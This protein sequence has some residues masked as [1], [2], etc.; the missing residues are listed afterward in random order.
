MTTGSVIRTN[1]GSL[2]AQN[3]LNRIY[4]QITKT[5]E[6][7]STGYKVNS[8]SDDAA[9]YA[10]GNRMLSQIM[11]TDVAVD[12]MGDGISLIATTD[13]GLTEI[14]NILQRIRE[15]TVGVQNGSNSQKDKEAVSYEIAALKEE[16]N[17]VSDTL[18]F[19]GVKVFQGTTVKI[20]SG[21]NDGDMIPV[22]VPKFSTQTLGIADFSV[23]GPTMTMAVATAAD[24]QKAFGATTGVTTN[25]VTASA[26]DLAGR[27][28][29]ATASV[30]FDTPPVALVDTNTNTWF[31]RVTITAAD[32][33][34]A[35][36]LK[37][38]G[39]NVEATVPKEF[40][41]SLDPK[42]AVVTGTNAAFTVDTLNLNL[43]RINLP[44]TANPLQTVDLALGRLSD[45]RSDLGATQKRL[46]SAIRTMQNTSINLKDSLSRIR[47]ADY[48]KEM[49]DATKWE[50]IQQ[51]AM[52]SLMRI[53]ESSKLI[54]GLLR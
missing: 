14:N 21:P 2:V 18:E 7:L 25:S 4:D 54:L 22:S 19:N 17:R 23:A 9:G 35:A 48:A 52:A 41:I 31:M 50:V 43:R 32:A 28:G 44:S 46:E 8:P 47:D 51:A 37:K 10:I 16:I 12:K 34:E 13:S 11:G 26:A 24:Y 27:L 49:S 36:N 42:E 53:N 20:V 45:V 3:N 38:R 29:V 39:F 30:V 15:L 33:T 5:S 1:Y 40:F 6:H